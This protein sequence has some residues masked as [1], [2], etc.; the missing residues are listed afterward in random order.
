ML[1]DA[2]GSM[3]LARSRVGRTD[4][5]TAEGKVVTHVA[6]DRRTSF[7]RF[8]LLLVPPLLVLVC[9]GAVTA[10]AVEV[11]R[12]SIRDAASARVVDVAAGFAELEQVR[13]VLQE[14][15]DPHDR[16]ERTGATQE[17]QPLASLVERSSGVDYVVVIDP[18]GLRLTHPDPEERGRPVST[19]SSRVLAG[20]RVVE[21]RTGTIGRTLRAKLPVRNAQGE[22]IGAVSAGMFESRM[23]QDV[24]EALRT[25]LPWTAGALVVGLALSTL[26]SASIRRRFHLHDEAAREVDRLERTS[27]ALREQAHEFDTR[28]HVVRGLVAHGDIAEALEYI[29]SSV[30]VT[31]ASADEASAG[32]PVLRA[33]L[34]ALRAELDVL[35]ASLETSIDVVSRVDETV[36]LVVA[37]LCRNAGEAGAGRGRCALQEADGVFHGEVADDGDGIDLR[38][39]HSLFVRGF[40][41]KPDRTGTGRGIGL[42]MVRRTVAERGGTIEA[43]TSELG[44]ARFAFDMRVEETAAGADETRERSRS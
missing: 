22:V 27:G 15:E 13:S 21:V 28:L 37:N 23:T 20:E 10:I 31:S 24:E 2:H 18:A 40:T 19:D 43:G 5:G 30:S 11:Q 26:M 33:T 41:S 1:I 29:D 42:A 7:S 44:G 17:L 9:V 32:Q 34:E 6:A 12:Q 38:Q 3:C 16:A 8:L 35:G 25:L 36:L 4:A 14:L 39:R